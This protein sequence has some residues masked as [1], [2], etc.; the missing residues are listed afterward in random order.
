M[1]LVALIAV[2]IGLCALVVVSLQDV[3][4]PPGAKMTVSFAMRK[5]IEAYPTFKH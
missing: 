2:A 3:R 1:P 5:A 4:D